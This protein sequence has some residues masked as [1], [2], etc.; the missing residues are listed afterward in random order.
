MQFDHTLR[1]LNRGYVVINSVVY[2]N[3]M[4][5]DAYGEN[6]LQWEALNQTEEVNGYRH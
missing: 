6:M 2:V 1:G 3:V 4:V 5:K